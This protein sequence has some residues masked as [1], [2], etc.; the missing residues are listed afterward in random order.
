MMFVNDFIGNFKGLRDIIN[1][2]IK[3]LFPLHLW[4][5]LECSLIETYS[6][7]IILFG[8][9]NFTYSFEKNGNDPL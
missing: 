1:I 2:T 9:L 7:T 4:T 8:L 6:N 3:F 5:L